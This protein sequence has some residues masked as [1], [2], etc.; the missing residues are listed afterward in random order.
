MNRSLGDLSFKNCHHSLNTPLACTTDM[1]SAVSDVLLI[2]HLGPVSSATNV[3]L[4]Y[5][6]SIHS[7]STVLKF[8]PPFIHVRANNFAA[9][10]VIE[11]SIGTSLNNFCCL[12]LASRAAA[13]RVHLVPTDHPC[14]VSFKPTQMPQVRKQCLCFAVQSSHAQWITPLNGSTY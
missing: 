12:R 7:P 6:L 4:V 14:L 10:R 3:V 9:V 2:T 13:H 11:C 5:I 1:A 8:G